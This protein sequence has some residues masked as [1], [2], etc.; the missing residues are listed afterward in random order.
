[1]TNP[2]PL[3][4]AS[5]L[6]EMMKAV[7]DDIKVVDASWHLPNANRDPYKE[8]QQ[9]RIPGSVFFDIDAIADDSVDLPHML[10]SAEVFS[11]AMSSL[12]I[13]RS[14][15]VVVY[16]SVGILAVDRW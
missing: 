4:S 15:T 6:Q 1:M 3:I 10:P 14:T 13:G 16:D 2:S 8:H 11:K 9:N 5:Q 7:D 12:G